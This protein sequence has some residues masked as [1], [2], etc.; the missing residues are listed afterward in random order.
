[1]SILLVEDV[2]AA[3]TSFVR[4]RE[5]LKGSL[6]KLGRM[7]GLGVAGLYEMEP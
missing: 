2:L 4:F 6:E 3:F 1:M 5:S 7:G